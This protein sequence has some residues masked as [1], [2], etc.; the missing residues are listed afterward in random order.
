MDRIIHNDNVKSSLE[1]KYH[2]VLYLIIRLLGRRQ[3]G[4]FGFSRKIV[5]I[6]YY[7]LNGVN[8]VTVLKK[9]ESHIGRKKGFVTVKENGIR[10][11]NEIM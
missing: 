4:Y 5:Q 11:E 1:E 2:I 8:L 7:A 10:R 9:K 6:T 3:Y